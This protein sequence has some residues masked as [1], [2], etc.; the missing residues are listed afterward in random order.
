MGMN[1]VIIIIL[2][3]GVIIF[4]QLN[5]KRS[6]DDV[7]QIA[8]GLILFGGGITLLSVIALVWIKP[9]TPNTFEKNLKWATERQ[10]IIYSILQ[11]V[12]KLNAPSTVE[13][14]L[15]EDLLRDNQTNDFLHY[16]KRGYS[17]RA[18]QI[19]RL[20]W[21]V[22]PWLSIS[23][24]MG[25]LSGL[26][27]IL[28]AIGK[29]ITERIHWRILGIGNAVLASIG[30]IILIFKITFLDTLGTTTNIKINLIAALAEIEITFAPWWMVLG[31]FLIMLSGISFFLLPESAKSNDIYLQQE[32]AFYYE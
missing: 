15:L 5:A 21:G 13:N 20:C 4:I 10:E 22:S 1:G 6:R 12:P 28:I 2:I 3:I 23:L 7:A 16:I 25:A 14:I 18:W 31:L 11:Q 9:N 29:M 8:I 19:G 27:G 17:L 26:F 30:F 32:G 24:I